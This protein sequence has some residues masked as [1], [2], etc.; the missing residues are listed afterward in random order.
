MHNTALFLT[1]LVLGLLITV[2]LYYIVGRLRHG[3]KR[4]QVNAIAELN[5]QAFLRCEDQLK[6]K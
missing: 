5:K 3:I 2:C 1:L 4:K 6:A